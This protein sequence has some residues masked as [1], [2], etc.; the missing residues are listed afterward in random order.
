MQGERVSGA[1]GAGSATAHVRYTVN[2]YTLLCQRA[3]RIQGREQPGIQ[4]ALT[5]GW[6]TQLVGW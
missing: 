6:L 2:A 5:K 1:G 3:V 4:Q